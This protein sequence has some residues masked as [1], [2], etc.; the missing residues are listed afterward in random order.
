MRETHTYS[1]KYPPKNRPTTPWPYR[2]VDI[3]A[4]SADGRTV[5]DPNSLAIAAYNSGLNKLAPVKGLLSDIS[6]QPAITVQYDSVDLALT[7]EE[8]ERLAI[9]TL[10]PHEFFA[11]AEKFGIFY[12]IHGGY[13]EDTGVSYALR[14]AHLEEMSAL[15]SDSIVMLSSTREGRVR[16][17]FEEGP[18]MHEGIAAD[19]AELRTLLLNLGYTV[20]EPAKPCWNCGKPVTEVQRSENDGFC[21]HCNSELS[22]NES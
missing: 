11:L 16:V 4:I 2:S 5:F 17:E 22:E 9:K 21:P 6:G 20:A 12:E 7:I 10:A 8:F 15:M 14:A 3:V 18:V 13:D 19:E 1:D